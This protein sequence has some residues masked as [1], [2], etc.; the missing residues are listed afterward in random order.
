VAVSGRDQIV[1]RGP[2][3][4]ERLVVMSREVVPPTGGE[5]A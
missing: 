1:R 2:M 3:S 4:M 5:S